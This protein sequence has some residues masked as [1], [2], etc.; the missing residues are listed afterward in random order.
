VASGTVVIEA[1]DHFFS[2]SQLT[3]AVGTTVVWRIVG[4]NAHDIT[5]RDGSFASS[6]LNFGS[7][8]TY[9]YNKPGLYP[10][11]CTLHEGDGM[12]AEIMVV[13]R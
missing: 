5:A 2:P 11:V 1:G 6:A 4:Q 12:F 10:Y 8:F 9:T 3:V 7:R 13:D